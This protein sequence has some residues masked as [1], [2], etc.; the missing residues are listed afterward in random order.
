[1]I[2]SAQNIYN[3]IL[4]RIES[5]LPYG[6]SLNRQK[7]NQ[8]QS[9]SANGET[10][11]DSVQTVDFREILQAYVDTMNKT[12]AAS[13][14]LPGVS[15]AQI[16]EAVASAISEASTKYGVDESLIK[17]IIK[18]ESNYNQNAVSRAG[19][20]GLMQLMPGTADYLNVDDAFD[21]EDNI[22]G[23]TDYIAR[24]L[25]KYNGDIETALAAYNAGPGNV[26]K[27]GGMPPFKETQGYVPKVLN[28]QKSYLLEQYKNNAN[29]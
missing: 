23:G 8:V 16:S 6:V 5:R 28:Y 18:V 12:N 20:M 22:D 9:A 2:N 4:S 21:I 10:A 14:S 25:K 3:E 24:L 7:T 26:A 19:A 13:Y 11:G 29:L 27:Y 17:A 15:S 1:M